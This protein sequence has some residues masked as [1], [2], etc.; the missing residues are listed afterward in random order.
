MKHV[1]SLPDEKIINNI[2]HLRGKKVML[3]FDLAV[4]YGVEVKQLKRQVRRNMERFPEDFMFAL[5][6][7]DLQILRRQFGTSSWGG[8]RYAP[9][10]FTEQ[11]V[12]ML[13]SVLFSK[14]AVSVNVQIMRIF[15][16]MRELLITHKDILLKLEQLEK[17][18]LDQDTYYKKHEEEIQ[19]IFNALKELLD[20]PR[21]ARKRVGYRRKAEDE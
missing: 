15:T 18:V 9:M 11:G 5:T 19:L 20:P 14:R 7:K 2:R 4:L 6:R 8:S 10:A 16:R 17:K 12:A 1:I 3:D 13:S 21:S